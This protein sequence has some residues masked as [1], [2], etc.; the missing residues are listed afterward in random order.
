MRKSIEDRLASF[1]NNALTS[2]ISVSNQG[3]LIQESIKRT[4]RASNVPEKFE[5]AD[6]DITND[7]RG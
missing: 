4:I 7:F 5:V 1:E 3:E 6:V 2:E